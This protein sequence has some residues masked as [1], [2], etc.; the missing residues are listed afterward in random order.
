MLR[1]KLLDNRAKV[2]TRAYPDDAGLDLYALEDTVVPAYDIAWVRTGIA[3]EV[4]SERFGLVAG[5]S[6]MSNRHL[7]LANGIGVGDSGYRGELLICLR[8][9][10][11]DMIDL[12][13]N[14][15]ER[16]AQLIIVPIWR[17]SVQVVDELSPSSRGTNGWGS[18][19][20]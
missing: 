6:G 14:A 19:G 15:G 9:T 7:S 18:T 8:N 5:R 11:P 4:P 17:P 20:R 12:T 16:V 3:V 10:H 2:P 1:V 13:V